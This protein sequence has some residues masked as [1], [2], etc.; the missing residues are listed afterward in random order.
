MADGVDAAVDPVKPAGACAERDGLTAEAELDEPSGRDDSVLP[1]RKR[2]NSPVQ[3]QRAG[4]DKH[5]LRFPGPLPP[6]DPSVTTN[7]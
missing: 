7:A 3:R 4:F 2:R 5:C 1:G 6:H